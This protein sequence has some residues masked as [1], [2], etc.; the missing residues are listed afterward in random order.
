MSKAQLISRTACCTAWAVL[1]AQ[2]TLHTAV[3]MLV[4]RKL[5]LAEAEIEQQQD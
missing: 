4:F 3:G 2:H 5:G 1:C